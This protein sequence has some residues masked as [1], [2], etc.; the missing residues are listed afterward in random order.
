MNKQLFARVRAVFA[1]AAGSAAAIVAMFPALVLIACEAFFPME[2]EVT[3]PAYEPP[4]ALYTRT[5]QGVLVSPGTQLGD[6]ILTLDF[7]EGEIADLD[8]ADISLTTDDS[9]CLLSKQGA[10]AAAGRPGTYTLNIG[11]VV[12]GGK[13]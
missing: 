1:V 6:Q 10:L 13:S 4:P 12:V 7:G 3:P 5:L 2:M 9:D 8:K 11:A